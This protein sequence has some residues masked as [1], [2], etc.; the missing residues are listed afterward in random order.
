MM[1]FGPSTL[2]AVWMSGIAVSYK[3]FLTRTWLAGLAHVVLPNMDALTPDCERYVDSVVDEQRD[4]EL[5][6]DGVQLPGRVDHDARVARLVPVLDHGHAAPQGLAHHIA[7][8]GPAQYG[9]GRVR[10]QVERVV[11]GP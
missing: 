1:A 7:Q 5:A 4:A 11:D 3:T 2:R 8:I 10:H 6:R 9:R